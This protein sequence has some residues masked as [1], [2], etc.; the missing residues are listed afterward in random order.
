MLSVTEDD[1]WVTVT[2][3]LK[4]STGSVPADQ[5]PA[6]RQLLLEEQDPENR[7]VLLKTK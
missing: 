3:E 4:L 7:T 5:W 1:E 2:R 6:L